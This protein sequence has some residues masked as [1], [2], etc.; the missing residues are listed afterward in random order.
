MTKAILCCIIVLERS[1]HLRVSLVLE[2]PDK[3][4]I[5]MVQHP[6]LSIYNGKVNVLMLSIDK[7]EDTPVL[8]D[9]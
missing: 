6:S 2:T 5:S 9:R 7:V 3:V 4:R 8:V 1:G